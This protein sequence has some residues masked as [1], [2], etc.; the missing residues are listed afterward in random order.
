MRRIKAF[1]KWVYQWVTVISVTLLGFLASLPDVFN[2]LGDVDL[3]P[4]LPPERALT[5]MTLIAIFKAICAAIQAKM[6]K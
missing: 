5:I 1:L 3:K 4:L 2:A 6:A